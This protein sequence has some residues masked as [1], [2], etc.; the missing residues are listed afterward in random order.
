MYG[1]LFPNNYK[2][3]LFEWELMRTSVTNFPTIFMILMDDVFQ[4][5]LNNYVEVYAN[6][7]LVFNNIVINTFNMLPKCYKPSISI[8][9]E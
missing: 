3:T 7:I 4:P 2:S 1:T 6:D 5:F 8:S 9:H